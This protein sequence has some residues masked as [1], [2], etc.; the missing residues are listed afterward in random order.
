L[1]I[2]LAI[3]QKFF[4]Q[5]LRRRLDEPLEIL[6]FKRRALELDVLRDLDAVLVDAVL[7]CRSSV[8]GGDFMKHLRQYCSASNC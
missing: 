5:I 8:T 1:E 6:D 4:Y 3:F 2:D 7:K